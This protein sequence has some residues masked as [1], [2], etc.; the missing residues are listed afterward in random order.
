MRGKKGDVTVGTLVSIVLAIVVIAFLV[1][2]FSTG[3][4]NLWGKVTDF[5]AGD[6]NVGDI[7]IACSLACAQNKQY[8]FCESVKEVNFG[9]KKIRDGSVKEISTV[10]ATC[11]N[12]SKNEN[13]VYN[14]T[15]KIVETCNAITC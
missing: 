6:S 5:G 12:L 9:E 8:D 11:L 1:Y 13:N 7:S 3:W 10:K 2:G 4:S 14:V 15:T